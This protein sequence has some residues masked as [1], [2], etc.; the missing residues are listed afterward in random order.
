[1]EWQ[2]TEV[3]VSRCRVGQQT[4]TVMFVNM[5]PVWKIDMKNIELFHGNPIQFS[6]QNQTAQKIK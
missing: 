1:M 4:E 5:T 3:Y 2:E 6:W